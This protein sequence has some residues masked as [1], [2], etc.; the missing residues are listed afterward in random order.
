MAF[1]MDL[2][3]GDPGVPSVVLL[4]DFFGAPFVAGGVECLLLPVPQKVLGG[5]FYGA[6][7][8]RLNLLGRELTLRHPGRGPSCLRGW[9]EQRGRG[10]LQGV[11]EDCKVVHV[12]AAVAVLNLA[13]RRRRDDPARRFDPCGKLP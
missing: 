12:H 8:P 9:G 13:Q 3:R 2:A 7:N 6:P 10:G 5:E 11:G 4:K 1:L